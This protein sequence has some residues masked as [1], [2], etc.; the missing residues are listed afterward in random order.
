MVGGRAGGAAGVAG[1]QLAGAGVGWAGGG[2]CRQW[3][4][5]WG[6]GGEGRQLEPL[7]LGRT[8]AVDVAAHSAAAMRPRSRSPR[9]FHLLQCTRR[10]PAVI[11]AANLAR[12]P[13]DCHLWVW[14]RASLPYTVCAVKAPP[15]KP[16]PPPTQGLVTRERGDSSTLESFKLPYCHSAPGPEGCPDLLSAVQRLRPT[17][18]IGLSTAEAPPFKFTPEVLRVS[19]AGG[20]SERVTGT[21]RPPTHPYRGS[22]LYTTCPLSVFR[23]HAAPR[24]PCQQPLA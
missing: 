20:G 14:A 21:R 9:P 7:L 6:H 17:V 1:A 4:A 16:R 12:V 3:T 24:S 18:L 13:V 23:R 15:Y 11:P 10:Q 8:V 22:S 2:L 5:W 19:S